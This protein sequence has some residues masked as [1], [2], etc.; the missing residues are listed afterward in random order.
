MEIAAV[1][2]EVYGK[3]PSIKRM[4]SLEDLYRTMHQVKQR[5]PGNM[6]AWLGM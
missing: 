6:W 4:G 3:E 1:F 2:K 5:N